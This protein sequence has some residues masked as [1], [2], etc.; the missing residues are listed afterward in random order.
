VGKRG[1]PCL[2]KVLFK[3]NGILPNSF[4][5]AISTCNYRIILLNMVKISLSSKFGRYH[6]IIIYEVKY[7]HRLYDPGSQQRWRRG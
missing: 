1:S 7:F 5:T 2:E 3:W 4:S 6:T